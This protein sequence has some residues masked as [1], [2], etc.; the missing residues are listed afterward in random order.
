MS[1]QRYFADL[2][3]NKAARSWVLASGA[4]LIVCAGACAASLPYPW[5]RL[6]AAAWVLIACRELFRLYRV[7][8]RFVRIRLFAD[9]SVEL[10]AAGGQ[11]HAG[12]LTAGSVA[13]DRLAWLRVR[14]AGGG[15]SGDLLLGN[16]RKNE[17]WR[18]FRVIF[19]HLDTC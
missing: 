7:Y 19:R 18:R 15:T 9:G 14:H 16:G 12:W 3:A 8:R 17:Q 1:S 6:A 13:L 5:L 2:P 11:R 10:L 4:L